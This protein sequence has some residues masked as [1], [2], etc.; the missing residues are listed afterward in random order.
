MIWGQKHEALQTR[1][2]GHHVGGGE[3]GLQTFQW[4]MT[5]VIGTRRPWPSSMTRPGTRPYMRS[6]LPASAAASCAASWYT[7]SHD[8][9]YDT[10]MS[11]APERLLVRTCMRGN[12]ESAALP[13]QV[14]RLHDPQAR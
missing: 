2:P 9:M 1:M 6:A 3:L 5:V 8:M 12:R 7:V 13:V 10:C 14:L 11:G 4:L